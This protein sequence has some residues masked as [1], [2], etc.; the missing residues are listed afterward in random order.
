MARPPSASSPATVD[1]DPIAAK[2]KSLGGEVQAHRV[3][4]EALEAVEAAAAAAEPTAANVEHA[5]QEA[6]DTAPFRD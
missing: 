4:A 2:L 3:S 5:R 1:A 6:A